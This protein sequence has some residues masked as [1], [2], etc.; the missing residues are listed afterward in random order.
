M[1]VA[2]SGSALVLAVLALAVVQSD[3]AQQSLASAY[4]PDAAHA[5]P[6]KVP[7]DLTGAVAAA[8]QID[9]AAVADAAFV[10]CA[11]SKLMACYVGANLNCDKADTRRTLPGAAAWCRDNPGSTGVPMSATGH[12]TIYDWSCQGRRPVAGRPVMAVDQRG[13]IAD[14]WKEIR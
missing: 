4:C 8:F 2:I 11:G 6:G 3:A 7:A 9:A 5:R 12:A 10:R 13:Y 14:N 1:R